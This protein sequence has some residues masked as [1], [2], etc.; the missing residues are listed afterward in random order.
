MF[1]SSSLSFFLYPFLFFSLWGF[2]SLEMLSSELKGSE[3]T[4]GVGVP[5][6]SVMFFIFIYFLMLFLWA[7]NFLIL[8]LMV[9]G[10]LR[11]SFTEFSG[12]TKTNSKREVPHWP[13]VRSLAKLEHL[14]NV[15]VQSMNASRI[16][17]YEAQSSGILERTA[18]APG[19][20]GSNGYSRILT[21]LIVWRQTF[22]L[23]HK[24]WWWNTCSYQA[25][26]QIT[27]W[28]IFQNPLILLLSHWYLSKL[29]LPREP[30]ICLNVMLKNYS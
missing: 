19:L 20:S 23:L 11:N 4:F 30:C 29:L 28:W 12:I 10:A 8:S 5:L 2:P 3:S 7:S 6:G 21:T 18:F 27:M 26:L 9:P 17:T 14:K 15:K 1:S 16:N 22:V 25:G 24:L 13:I